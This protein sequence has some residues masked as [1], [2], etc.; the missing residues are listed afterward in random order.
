MLDVPVG[1]GVALG[2]VM[3]GACGYGDASFPCTCLLSAELSP[4]APEFPLCLRRVKMS[5]RQLKS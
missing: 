5:F 1:A 2:A 4:L 3:A